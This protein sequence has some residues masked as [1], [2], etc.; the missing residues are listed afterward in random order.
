MAAADAGEHF[1][2][3][4]ENAIDGGVSGRGIVVMDVLGKHLA[5]GGGVFRELAWTIRAEFIA[6]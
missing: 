6:S 4:V 3:R 1:P 2:K 5:L